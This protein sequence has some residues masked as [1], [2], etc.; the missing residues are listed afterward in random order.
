MI[1]EFEFINDFGD[2]WLFQRTEVLAYVEKE[3]C[4]YRTRHSQFPRPMHLSLDQ[5]HAQQKSSVFQVK[6]QL[7]LGL[8]IWHT[9][10]LHA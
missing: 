7:K 2:F 3:L 9:H 1:N 4:E 5:L 6:K 8:H 10:F